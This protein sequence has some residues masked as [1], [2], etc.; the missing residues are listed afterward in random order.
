LDSACVHLEKE[1]R[2]LDQHGSDQISTCF[3]TKSTIF[4]AQSSRY[5]SPLLTSALR[6]SP[7]TPFFVR[8]FM[9]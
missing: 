9:P 8:D 2:R 1:L 4:S 5:S 6:G 7:S 3:R